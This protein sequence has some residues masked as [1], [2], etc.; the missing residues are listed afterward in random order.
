M[1][2][3]KHPSLMAVMAL[4]IAAS[5]LAPV[6]AAADPITDKQAQAA[7][8]QDQIDANGNRISALGEQLNGA[9]LHLD[10]ANQTIADAEA[11]IAASQA[12]ITRVRGLVAE[13]AAAVY[14][15]AAG[16]QS[17]AE[18]DLSD[19]HQLIKRQKYAAA[20]ANQDNSLLHQLQDAKTQLAQQRAAAQKAQA[21]AVS[22]RAQLASTEQ[23]A[24]AAS[25]QQQQLLGQVQGELATLVQAE[26]QRR[27]AAATAAAQA[28]YSGRVPSG[29]GNA[30]AFPNVPPPSGA[31]STAIAY[32]RA[33]LGKPYQYAATGPDSFDCSGL[34][35][36]AW[37]AAGVSLPHYSGAQYSSLPHVPLSEMQPGDLVFW[38]SGGG[39]H[40]G[41]YVGNGMMI[42]APH[43][44]DVVK[45][46]PVYG[47]PVGAARP[48][49]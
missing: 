15:R 20:Q 35:M 13:R 48:G 49:V 46:A 47:S 11:K 33:Q 23:A 37:R 31:A 40:V 3:M 32:A 34:T 26:Q 29:D 1:R 43:T 45:V 27:T 12:E 25:A 2:I 9:Q 44:G 28:K 6:V 41:I 4:G 36:M 5:V 30:G 7:A 19:A 8:I 42:H 16:G 10:Q 18:F 38:G 14:R 21:D 17:L 39:S 24:E 22:E